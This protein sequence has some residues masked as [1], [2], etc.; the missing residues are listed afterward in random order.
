MTHPI[1]QKEEKKQSGLNWIIQIGNRTAGSGTHRS[2]FCVCVC[3]EMCRFIMCKYEVLF[4]HFHT[5]LAQ[6]WFYAPIVI[7]DS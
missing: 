7:K 2:S 6:T 1:I 5:W 3:K 4:Q